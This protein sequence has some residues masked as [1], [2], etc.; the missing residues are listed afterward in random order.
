[1]LYLIVEQNHGH[2]SSRKWVTLHQKL[3]RWVIYLIEAEYLSFSKTVL[4]GTKSAGNFVNIHLCHNDLLI[5]ENAI[6]MNVCPNLSIKW[7][8]GLSI[9]HVS[10]VYTSFLESIVIIQ[11]LST[12]WLSGSAANMRNSEKSLLTFF[13]HCINNIY[14]L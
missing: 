8:W 3:T 13:M 9:Y 10:L 14:T 2:K 1:M 5:F 11:L 7:P 4:A 6:I 12:L